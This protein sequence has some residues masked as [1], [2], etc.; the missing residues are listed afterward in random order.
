MNGQMMQIAMQALAPQL[1]KM[2]DAILSIEKQYNVKGACI[3]I[4]NEVGPPKAVGEPNT[5]VPVV[6]YF[7][8]HEGQMMPIRDEHGKPVRFG[9]AQIAN[10]ISGGA[11]TENQE[12]ED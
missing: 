8:L 7:H 1:N 3:M 5:L 11:M 9:V 12:E 2:A 4:M 10:L 6:L